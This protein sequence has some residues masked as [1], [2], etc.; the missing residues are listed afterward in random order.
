MSW[1]DDTERR[2]LY[3][4]AC[5]N[6]KHVHFTEIEAGK[7]TYY[8]SFDNADNCREFGFDSIPE[9]KAALDEL[10]SGQPVFEPV[11]KICLVAAFKREPD[12]DGQVKANTKSIEIPDFVYAF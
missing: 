1:T 7:A 10:W 9:L 3:E 11:K 8:E 6:M 2:K 5:E 12:E 4:W